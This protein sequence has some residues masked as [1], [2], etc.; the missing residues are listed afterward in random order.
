MKI[1]P[2]PPNETER[3][4]ALTRYAILDTP[5]DEAFDELTRLA[6]LICQVPIALVSLLDCNRQWFKSK[7]GVETQE[8]CRDF[9][10]CAHAILK[11]QPMVVED[12]LLDERFATNPLVISAPNI[13]FYA[14]F[15]LTTRD[16]FA[17][18]TLCVIDYV[19]RSL[20]A[21]Q[22]QT[23]QTLANQVVTQLELKR[24]LSLVEGILADL[25]MRDRAIAASSNGIIITDYHQPDH[26]IIYVNSAF[27]QI[28]GY[29]A[30]EAIG[31]NSRFL[32]GIDT[33][34]PELNQLRAAVAEG[35]ACSVIL[36]NYRKDG[37]QFW[38]ELHVSPVQDESG[39]LTH[40]IGIQTDITERKQSE[41]ALRQQMHRALLLKRITDEIRRS[42][43]TEQ[44]FRTT[45]TQIGRA[46]QV[47][48]CL[49]YRYQ[50]QIEHILSLVAEYRE[51]NYESVQQTELSIAGNPYI[52][53]ILGQ[54]RAISSENVY[55]DSRLE[56][57]SEFCCR[58]GVRSILAIRTSSQ[59][60][61]N[62]VIVL[63]QCQ[64]FHH[65]T[66]DEIDLLEA[67]AAQVG[68]A[69]T[70]ARLLEQ[71]MAQR[72]QLARQ[73]HELEQARQLAEMANRAKSEF[74][75]IMSHEIRTPMNAILGMTQLLLDTPLTSQQQDFVEI[76]RNA[77]DTLLTVINDILDFSK[78]ESSKLELEEQPFDLRA[79]LE[80]ALDLLAP[81]AAETGLE[82]IYL[83]S[84]QT[85]IQVVGDVTRLRQILVNL[86]CN[87]I[88]FT[89][90]GEVLVFVDARALQPETRRY[91]IQF[92]VKDTGIGIPA[93]RQNRLFK[94]FSQV[95]TSTTRQYGGTGLGLAISRRLSELMGGSMWVNSIEGQGSTF[96]FTI[97]VS[98][99]P[100]IQSPD[101][102]RKTQL[103]VLRGKRGLIVDDNVA[104]RQ[105]LTVQTHSWGLM[106][107]S[108]GTAIE[109]L[110]LVE[111]GEPFDVVILDEQLPE[112]DSIHLIQQL[113]QH[114]GQ[115]HLPI[116]MLM[117]FGSANLSSA[118]PS[119][120]GMNSIT[121]PNVVFVHKPIKQ[122]HLLRALVTTLKQEP[123][124]PV[125]QEELRSAT[126]QMGQCYPLRILLAEDNCVN[127][128]VALHLLQRL[129]YQADVAA[130][131]IEVLQALEQQPYDV[132]LM[133]MQM[134]E[135]D[136]I[137]ATQTIHQL[138]AK[139]RPRIIAVTASAMQSDREACLKAGMDDYMSKP[140]QMERLI[141]VLKQS[142]F[143]K[144][145]KNCS[146]TSSELEPQTL[147]SVIE[148][149]ARDKSSFVIELIDSYLEDSILLLE[150]LWSSIGLQDVK[151]FHR[152]VHT[153]KA[154]STVLGAG[155]LS[156]RCRKL[157]E[158][159]R[160][161][162]P[163][164]AVEQLIQIANEFDRVA[165]LLRAERQ[166]HQLG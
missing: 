3:L 103:H 35:R 147:L 107:R 69:L 47:S 70:Q 71:E 68:I 137:Q 5:P 113:R 50:P 111:Q 128:K 20:D 131:G 85:P 28:T 60:Q 105:N 152:T 155:T 34:Q 86:I 17:L 143:L 162:I 18:G 132:I 106:T 95:D 129:G 140:I 136:G 36:R 79:C 52:Q 9:A 101:F 1:A 118:K 45:A 65:W 4:Q 39:T 23:L 13:R 83:M 44:I 63:H 42:L 116:V 49:I 24:N 125:P 55:A 119:L 77:G 43:D 72:E 154:N 84:E 139:D 138:Y 88:K 91:E 75:A 90:A 123:S 6:A 161:Q 160:D 81:K 26:P 56:N 78:I 96:H 94:P 158:M 82:L 74:L 32:Q 134:P 142:Y 27:E 7:V 8:T 165:V 67:V 146:L 53:K 133:D 48:R 62:G 151:T 15:P 89:P 25:R 58:H 30:A 145:D 12:A 114:S 33:E 2:L 19:P 122:A 73:N 14:G 150:T 120:S 40:F 76:A 37:T 38:N 99:V 135:M 46:F 22:F 149:I 115:C 29:T 144:E 41:N 100:M 126:V 54:D 109:A 16:G 61:A 59:N 80:G 121:L 148:D 108:V 66:D 104:I 153:L 102:D 163:E 127:Q 51:P 31:R 97:Q 98:A 157:E 11:P 141:L 112:G 57:L 124:L 117:Q 93:D 166:K 87:A 164:S 92:S 64:S 110:A 10:F 130:N 156:E 21:V 159:S